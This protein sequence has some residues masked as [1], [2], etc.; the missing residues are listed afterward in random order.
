MFAVFIIKDERLIQQ[1]NG[2]LRCIIQVN[3]LK[4][5]PSY[6]LLDYSLKTQKPPKS[7]I[8]SY[9][10]EQPSMAKFGVD[11]LQGTI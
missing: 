10:H 3:S 6:I 11:P 4:Y 8:F 2:G 9:A 7:I 1:T 5:L